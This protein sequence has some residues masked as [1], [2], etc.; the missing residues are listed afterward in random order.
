MKCLSA[1]HHDLI[2]TS[3]LQQTTAN[4][5]IFR[6]EAAVCRL[7]REYLTAQNFVE[8]HTPKIISGINS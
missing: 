2:L 1:I 6:V 8:I 3:P 4:Q 5:A 7:F